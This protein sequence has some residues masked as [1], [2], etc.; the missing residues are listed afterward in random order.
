[1]ADQAAEGEIAV[2]NNAQN[3]G[4]VAPQAGN[5]A[6]EAQVRYWSTLLRSRNKICGLSPE[7]MRVQHFGF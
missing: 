2:S 3:S 7:I 1:M 5:E 4:E 6:Q